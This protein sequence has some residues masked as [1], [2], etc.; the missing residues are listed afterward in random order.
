MPGKFTWYHIPNP[1]NYFI[2]SLLIKKNLNYKIMKGND[3][4]I[5]KA[6]E[7]MEKGMEE[8]TLEE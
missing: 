2:I 3:I 8:G 4:L 7:I 1:E 6:D 5:T